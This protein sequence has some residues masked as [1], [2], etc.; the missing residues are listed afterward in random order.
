MQPNTS[1]ATEFPRD[2]GNLVEL[3]SDSPPP[4]G[5]F[6]FDVAIVGLGYV[7]LP[8]ALAFHT[9]GARVLG[10][11]VSTERLVAIDQKNVDLLETDRLRL[12]VAVDDPAFETTTDTDRLREAAA[13]IVCVPTPVD[14]HLT[15]DLQALGAA[16]STVVDHAVTGQVLMLTSTSYVGCTR[17]LLIDPL[18]DRDL[19]VGSAVFV[20][21]SPERID[22]GNDRFSHEEVPR[23]IGGATPACTDAASSVLL[24]YTTR[25]HRVDS[26]E[27]AEA[28][29]LFEN[30]FRAVNIALANEFA[31]ICLTLDID[32]MNVIAA[33][34]TKPYGFMPFYPGPGVGGHCI[35]CDPHYLLW[36][37]R[38]ERLGAP[39][40]EQAM[41]AISARPH[42]VLE[43]ILHTLSDRGKGLRGTRIVVVGVA[44]KPDVGDHRESPALE[45][46]DSLLAEGADVVYHDPHFETLTLRSGA[47]LT[48][49][50]D[51]VA[52]GADLILVH[53]AHSDVDLSWLPAARAVLDMTYRQTTLAVTVETTNIDERRAS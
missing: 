11:D 23:V 24:R 33:A 27:V 35:P 17:D 38:K 48:G 22:P 41:T 15:P 43:Q 12:A 52:F 6:S 16:C 28:T 51:P 18:T 2:N 53:T 45:I 31:E 47:V 49:I 26:P 8:T 37:L 13:V 50:D 36:Q 21:F 46:L 7:G 9:A 19:P 44:Y 10:I 3:I 5:T 39:L 1:A 25:L 4:H 40:I 20:A 42:R 14:Q 32:V 29:K 34:A 30:T